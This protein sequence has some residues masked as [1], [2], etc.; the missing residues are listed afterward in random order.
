MLNGRERPRGQVGCG[1][2]R[3]RGTG[4]ASGD[5]LEL[6]DDGLA[7]MTAEQV[8]PEVAGV[9]RVQDTQHPPGDLGVVEGVLDVVGHGT[10]LDQSGAQA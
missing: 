6:G 5:R 4:K 8:Q 9:I 1:L 7:L 2:D 10:S 3:G